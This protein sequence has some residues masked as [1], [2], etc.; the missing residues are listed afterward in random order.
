LRIFVFLLF[1]LSLCA[2]TLHLATSA[3]PSRLNP[4][5]ATDSSSSEIAG[6][7]FNGL[8]KYDKDSQTII[9]DLAEK[10]YFL[11][12]NGENGK[13]LVFELRKGVKWHDGVEFSSD[14]VV[15]TY[16]VL[17]SNKISSPYSAGFRFVKSVEKVDKYTIKV[18][19]KQAYFKAVETWM[20]GIIPK[21][22]LENEENL[23]NSKFNI[24]PVGTGPYK[25]HQ[26][27][28]SKNI[29]LKANDDYFEGR[30]K[31]DEISYHVIAD[32]MTRFLMLKSGELDVGGIEPMQYERQLTP[33]FFEMYDIYEKMSLSYT[34]LGFNLRRQK[35]KDPRVREA[36]SIAIDREEIVKVL[37]FDHAEVCKG[38]FHPSSI[39]FNKDV[40]EPKKDL[41]RAK[42]LLADAGFNDSNPFSF[43]IVTSNSSAIRPYAAEIL[44]YQLKKIGVVV[45][46]RVMEWQAF[47]NMVVF[48]HKFDSVLL[49]WGLS[50]APDPYMFWHSDN[51]TKGGFNLVG[52]HNKEMNRMIEESQSIVDK[53][54]LAKKW[55]KMFKMIVEDNPYLFLYIPN[56]ITVINKKIKNVENSP[57]GIWH[58]YIKWEK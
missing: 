57:S 19:Y 42:K 43:E 44:Q 14:D 51:D 35:F 27:E 45:N 8:V 28:H 48:P 24:D 16:E 21:H 26:L 55:Q 18:H 38:P 53:K 4:I 50:P 2:S 11:K 46:L 22:I 13:T 15:F 32:P 49:G 6:H 10:F 9:G 36:L 23:M 34:Y 31:I 5:L 37:F 52:Y 12:E 58:N 20:M 30:P 54:I 25:L 3:N 33:D 7:I 40:Q 39:A 29:I 56:S 47:L 41:Q 1:S 17:T